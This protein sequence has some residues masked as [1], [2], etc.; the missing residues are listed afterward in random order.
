MDYE[1]ETQVLFARYGI[2]GY[3]NHTDTDCDSTGV[4]SAD[5]PIDILPNVPAVS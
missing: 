4:T 5:N 1:A 2:S 3:D